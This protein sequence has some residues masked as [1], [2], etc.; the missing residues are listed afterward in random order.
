M[1]KNMTAYEMIVTRKSIR[2]YLKRK[3]D[4]NDI[5][6]VLQA[7]VCAPSGKNGQPWRFRIILDDSI[8]NNLAECSAYRNWMREAKCIIVVFLDKSH[9]YDYIKDVQSCGASIQNILLAAHSLGLGSCWV[10]EILNRSQEVKTLLCISDENLELMGVVTLGYTFER[11]VGIA[12]KEVAD[13]L[14]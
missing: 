3:I 12:K 9:S 14:I 4:D 10:G 6:L 13:F 7:A 8:I 5:Q 11:K 1:R 2:S